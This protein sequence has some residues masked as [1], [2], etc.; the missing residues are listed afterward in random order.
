MTEMIDYVGGSMML[1]AGYDLV[2]RSVKQ[3]PLNSFTKA[4]E[5]AGPVSSELEF[6]ESAAH[7][8]ELLDIGAEGAYDS[9]LFSASGKAD[10]VRETHIDEYSL[11]F[12]VHVSCVNKT[13]IVTAPMLSA[14]AKDLLSHGQLDQFRQSYG[15]HYI[16]SVT[17]GGE[18]FGMIRIDTRSVS[19]NTRLSSE[20]SGSGFNWD[21][22]TSVKAFIQRAASQTSIN[23]RVRTS[24]ITGYH[25][26]TT[27]D[28]L[29]KLAEDFP[30][31]VAAQGTPIKVGLSPLNELPEVHM[32]VRTLNVPVRLALAELSDR[33]LDYT[34]LF[35]N[36]QFMLSPKGADRFD[37]DSVSKDTVR[38]QKDKVNNKL[39]DLQLLAGKVMSG[40]IAP[41]DPSIR[42][43]VP[44]YEF[45]NGLTLP[46]AI[47]TV[48]IG[49]WSIYP[50]PWAG[51][52]D[53]EMAGHRPWIDM[54]AQLTVIEG[55]SKLQLKVALVMTESG[56][57]NPT[58]FEGSRTGV[59][60]D[61][62][63]TGAQI[64][65]FE[66]SIG[67]L[68]ARG[69]EDDHKWHWYDGTQ[70][71]KRAHCRSDV[72]GNETG[73]IGADAIELNP[74][75]IIISCRTQKPSID[76]E[77]RIKLRIANIPTRRVALVDYWIRKPT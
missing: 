1:G 77:Q 24:G 46:N 75:R 14:Q 41:N 44:A 12:I 25:N 21:V 4:E 31:I 72:D 74:V 2:G 45:D 38:Q 5:G 59:V 57:H 35:N 70:L 17:R 50:L 15:D 36:I 29:I 33:Y 18:L 54:G 43:F 40:A 60:V 22:R 23:V 7:L 53:R 13:E 20:A 26:P 37:F 67:A 27:V 63:Y 68:R 34:V 19:D 65:G 62:K 52:D 3:S 69:G 39:Q 16:S 11:L 64:V 48:Q 71:I 10:F 28:D 30:A 73:R 47:D 51:G 42:T 66:P 9:L 49:N 58:K 56:R 8:N 32:D 6:I 55:R 76:R 61:L